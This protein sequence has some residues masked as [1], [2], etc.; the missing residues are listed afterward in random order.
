MRNS[1]AP[2]EKMKTIILAVGVLVLFSG[3][4]YVN[5][6]G[7]TTSYYSGCKEYYDSMGI[8]HK[9]CPKNNIYNKC[10]QKNN[11]LLKDCIGCN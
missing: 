3:C 7:A 2:R 4:V 1:L 6:C 10:K 5:E 11:S 9:E 8:Y